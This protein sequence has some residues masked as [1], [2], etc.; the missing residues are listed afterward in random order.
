M[1][2]RKERTIEKYMKAG[3]EMRLF[4]TVAKNMVCSIS[5]V[6]SA[7]DA[8][9]VLKALQVIEIVCVHA[10][11]NMFKDYPKLP[12]EY[13]DVFYGYTND[14]PRNAVDAMMIERARESLDELF[15]KAD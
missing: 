10:D 4:A 1:L 11:D 2:N 3:A 8:D 12:G 9:K 14:K 13:G 15:R 5:K 7:A 6:V